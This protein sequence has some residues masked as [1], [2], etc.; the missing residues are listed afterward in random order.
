MFNNISDIMGMIPTTLIMKMMSG[1][2]VSLLEIDKAVS[3][4]IPKIQPHIVE[5]IKN[6][7]A[8]KGNPIT[9]EIFIAEKDGVQQNELGISINE[10]VGDETIPFKRFM[11]QDIMKV[12]AAE[13]QDDSTKQLN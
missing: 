2:K 10:I 8:K 9:F 4:L 5:L 12:I 1:Q 13:L 7:Q 11:L 6:L 3:P